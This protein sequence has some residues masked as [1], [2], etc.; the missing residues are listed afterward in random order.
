[1]QK[2]AEHH[3]MKRSGYYVASISNQSN[4]FGDACK[5]IPIVRN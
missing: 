5:N 4:P 1:M 3:T 2:N